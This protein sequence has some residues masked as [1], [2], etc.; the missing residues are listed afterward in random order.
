LDYP[1]YV[2]NCL[3]TV[4]GLK[5]LGETTAL[6]VTVLQVADLSPANRSPIL[7]RLCQAE[8]PATW[9]TLVFDEGVELLFWRDFS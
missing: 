5:P 9:P 3:G 2:A 1:Q 7:R 6:R 4:R 8:V